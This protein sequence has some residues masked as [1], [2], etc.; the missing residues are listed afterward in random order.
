MEL[1]NITYEDTAGNIKVKVDHAKCINCGRCITACKHDSRLYTDA[2]SRFFA[3]LSAGVPISLIAAPSIRTNMP[4]YKRLFTYLKRCGVKKI[5]DVSLGADICIWA[6]VRYL[7]QNKSKRLITQPCPVIVSYFRLYR[8]DLL[9]YL[10]PVHSPMACIAV[11]MK[12]YEKIHD[13]IAALSPCIAK[14]DEFYDTKLTQYNITFSKLREYIDKY[15]IV[16]PDEEN[17]FDHY[18]S[19]IGSLFPMPGG[20]KENI[21]F[22]LGRSFSIDKAE[23]FDVYESLISYAATPS[24]LLPDIFDVLNCNDGC[25]IGPASSNEINKFH[26]N[27]EMDKNRE[28][29]THDRKME[30]FTA[31][32]ENYDKTFKITDF[33]RKYT[34]VCTPYPQI[35]DEDVEKAFVLMG[36]NSFEKK[37]VDCFAC[38]SKT[39]YDMARK[40]ALG[41]NIPTNCIVNA[42]ETA[43][44]EQAKAVIKA[45]EISDAQIATIHALVKAA[46]ARDDDTGAHIE[47]TSAYCRLIAEKLLEAG[48][49]KNIIDNDFTETISH[50]SPLHDIGK[51]GIQDAVLL[52]PDRLTDDEFE[53]V[54][55]HVSI[56][57]NTLASVENAYP[58]NAF[59][60]MGAEI[61]RYHHEKWDGSGYM[62]GL[63]GEEIPLS[64][65]IMALADVYDALRSKRVYKE[66]YSHD[67]AVD[68][69]KEGRGSHFDPNLT[70]VFLKHHLS[71]QL[72]F[73]SLSK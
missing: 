32:Y 63:K 6:H 65:R 13:N 66:G 26:I 20:L 14:A 48:I 5:Y 73:D 30:Y 16:L 34:P 47:R 60:K 11:Y 10:S 25:N 58:E 40:I 27:R 39:C 52:K 1:A 68:I 12:K 38:G 49:Y 44:E 71:F 57:Y 7:E 56:G 54:K 53:K 18:E 21:E 70:D 46:E 59:I 9:Q 19:G 33:M 31:L 15:N 51:I 72:I 69:I 64:A 29:A 3:D 4:D 67:G 36:K 62:D 45:H 61:A 17:G 37:N 24:E 35:T 50:A 55:T 8:H 41:V 22:F 28:M 2:T 42:M 23:G 43:R